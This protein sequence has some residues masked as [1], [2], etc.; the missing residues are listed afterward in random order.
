MNNFDKQLYEDIG[1]IKGK[2]EKIDAMEKDLKHLKKKIN[3]MYGWAAGVAGVVSIIF[4][5]IK[6][7]IIGGW[8]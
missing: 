1:Y 2:V 5:M 8:G 4:F 6:E 7:K 3:F